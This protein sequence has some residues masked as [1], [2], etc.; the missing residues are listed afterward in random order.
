MADIQLTDDLGKSAPDFKIDLSQPSSLLKYAKTELLH[1]AVAPDFIE[2]ASQPLTAAA[3]NPVSFQLKVQHQFQLGGTKPEIDLTPSF[4]V[5]IRANATEGSNL[6]ENDAFKVVSAVPKNTGY[7][8]L[9]LQGSLDLGVSGSSGSLTFGFGANRTVGLEYWK[10][11]PLGIAEPTLGNATGATISKYVIPA[12]V[13]DL[14]LLGINDVCT[15]SGQGSLKI[16]GGFT[17]TAAPNPLASVDLPLNAGKLEVKTGVIA[18]ITATFAITGSYQIRARRTSADT[19]ELSFHNQQGATLRT[20]LSASGGVAVKAGGSDLL[21]SLLGAISSDP[22]DDATKALFGDGGLSKNEISTLTDA[23]KN[24]LDQSLQASLDLALSQVADDEAA[25]QY[26]I[27]PADLN[28]TA[29]A[30][31]KLA[32]K[33]DLSDLTALETSIEGATLAPGVRLINSVLTTMR[34]RETSLKFNLFGLV[35]FISVADLIRKCVVVKDPDSGDLTIADSATGNLINAETEPYRRREALHKAM[36][37]SLMLTATY[38]VSKTVSMTGLT[39]KNFH[40]AFND[41]T[42]SAVIA[43][44]LNWFVVMNL[45]TRQESDDYLRHLEANGPS[46][47]LLRAEFDDNACLSMFFE[48]PGKLWDRDHYLEVGRQAMR[49]LIDRSDSD[50]NRYRYDLLDQRWEAAVKIGP[51][52]NLGP[53]MGLQL[54]DPREFNITQLLRSDVYTID[55]WATALQTAG[56]SILQMQQFLASANP[57]ILA[58]SPEF[59]SRRVQLQKTMAGVIRNSRTQFDEPWG[60]VSMFW[61]SGSKGAS[62]RLVA[63]GLLLVR[64]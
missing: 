37:E 59:V 42:N 28:A 23:I 9:A 57:G 38:R 21:R 13:E 45:L 43:D 17:V 2:R 20:D 25:F 31:L 33:G 55:W 53:L 58:G 15:V 56:A 32:L 63:K 34:K 41:R 50:T 19:I 1:L 40:F 6:F 60:L 3:P 7:V 54:T 5:I 35:N 24:S 16:S 51:N 46:T 52:D 14:N 61:A 8:S 64:P 36:F 48:S 26:E 49:A 22:N 12:E 30:A 11:F 47:C 4:Q 62:A 39:S 27:R 29:S 44:Y 10:A 18:G